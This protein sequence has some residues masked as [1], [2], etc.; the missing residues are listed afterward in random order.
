[1]KYEDSISGLSQSEKD[2]IIMGDL[3][4][5]PVFVML[6]FAL[7][8]IL[9]RIISKNYSGVLLPLLLSVHLHQGQLETLL[10]TTVRMIIM[11]QDQARGVRRRLFQ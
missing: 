7:G 9:G 11:K 5:N 3:A 4:H 1:M 8:L 6:G 2:S 10:Q